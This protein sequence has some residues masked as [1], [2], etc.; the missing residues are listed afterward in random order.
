VLETVL[1]IAGIVAGLTGAWSPCGF[2]MVD[3]L[4]P[5][6]YAGRLL[7]TLVAC[8]TFAAGAL[9]GGAITFGGLAWIGQSLGAGGTVAT[10]VAAVVALA[11]AIGEARGARIMPQVRRQVPESW[12]RVM[13]VPLA[14]GLYGVLLGL[15]FTTFILTFAVWALA[16]V[17]VAL[18]EPHLGLAVGLGFGLGRLLPVIVL[19]P[20][21]R[22]EWGAD[23][24]AAMA[25]R[26]AILRGLRAVD[27]VA[28]ALCALA[29]ATA[30]AQAA[31][32]AFRVLGNAT[33]PSTNGHD[34]L[35]WSAPG[36]V[37]YVRQGTTV[38]KVP[39]SHP[40]SGDAR[41]AW[42]ADNAIHVTGAAPTEIVIPAPGANALAITTSWVAWRATENGRD[43]LHTAA[44]PTGTPGPS[45]TAATGRELG[46]P[47]V[48]NDLLFFHAT[49][50]SGAVIRQLDL[51]TGKTT[52][53][54]R[55]SHSL[56]LNPSV[57]G[58][59]I[60]YVRST[61]RVQQLVIGP[62]TPRAVRHDRILWHTVET[63]RP[64]AGCEPG[65]CHALD[66]PHHAPPRPP[67]GRNDTL[68][69]T[70]LSPTEAYVTR[71]R[72]LTGKPVVATILRVPRH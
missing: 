62:I 5:Q 45:V 8:A 25:E 43:V 40:A 41:L 49:T 10:A 70:A 30:P 44:L 65:R 58:H 31:Q 33:D 71:L 54:R 67:K 50:R 48:D 12:R 26:P 3:T 34:V 69:T 56:L 39:G 9:V 1:I 16:G 27:A 55:Q 53:L 18:G 42:I 28:L 20:A 15:G 23:A 6:G 72:Q 22:T 61:A 29:L 11:A 60:I 68:W 66:H 7:T 24:H 35:A 32:R 13:P 2:S 38:T 36:G 64:D 17:S 52:T 57:L 59:R 4:A 37:G 46:R 47:A 51:S 21:A 14:A 63:G 19:A